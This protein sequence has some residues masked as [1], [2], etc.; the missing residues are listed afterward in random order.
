VTAFVDTDVLIC[1][2]K[3]DP[4]EQATRA[5]HLLSEADRLLLPG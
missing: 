3:G 2:L 5:T 1:Y 4:P